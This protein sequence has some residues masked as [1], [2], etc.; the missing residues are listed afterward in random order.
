M[1]L[2]AVLFPAER[3]LVARYRPGIASPAICSPSPLIVCD[4]GR[5]AA[6]HSHFLIRNGSPSHYQGTYSIAMATALSRS[7][8][9]RGTP[10]TS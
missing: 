2:A 10:L 1:D 7:Y 8:T 4:L 3:F 6:F 9:L 5:V